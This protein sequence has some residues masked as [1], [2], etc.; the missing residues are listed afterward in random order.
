MSRYISVNVDVDLSDFDTEDLVEEL[1]GRGHFMD[2]RGHFKEAHPYTIQGILVD[3]I[4]HLRR[5]GKDYEKELDE[6][7]Y[8]VTGRA[9]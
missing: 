1:N 9:I 8:I 7:L 5:E 4:F 6:Y 3:K 2:G